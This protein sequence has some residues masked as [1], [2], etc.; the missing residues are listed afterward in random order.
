[1]ATAALAETVHPQHD[2]N[3]ELE[4]PVLF[5]TGAYIQPFRI[6]DDKGDERWFWVVNEFVDDT[7]LDGEVINPAENGSTKQELLDEMLDGSSKQDVRVFSCVQC[8]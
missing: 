3:Y 2:R 5:T 6:V 8:G 1:M 4:E 7:F